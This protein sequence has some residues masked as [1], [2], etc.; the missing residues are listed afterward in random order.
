MN[1][2]RNHNPV[3]ELGDVTR[4]ISLASSGDRAAE[5]RLLETVYAELYAI[6][7]RAMRGERGG[8]TVGATA[9]VNEAYMRL[10]RPGGDTR[11]EVEDW[12][13]RRAFFQ[14]AAQAM[15]RVLIDH[16]RKRSA[17]VRGGGGLA[18]P[19]AGLVQT[20][21]SR[22]PLDI[23]AAARHSEPEELLALSEQILRLES[24]DPRAAEVVRLRFYAGLS[25]EQ[26]ALVLGLSERTV[27]RDWELARAWL[28]TQM[29]TQNVERA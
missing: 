17:L 22:V 1:T 16:A 24:V 7:Q 8:L 26:A 15:R 29:G 11:G 3:V 6:A 10:F 12:S 28:Q 9:I 2:E 21:A 18:E 4:L 13:S 25:V 23:L 14:V 27:K 19:G 5:G 20:K